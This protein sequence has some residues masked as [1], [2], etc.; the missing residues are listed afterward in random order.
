MLGGKEGTLGC[1]QDVGGDGE[2][3]RDLG[4]G[5]GTLGTLWFALKRD[6]EMEN[7]IAKPEGP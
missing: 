5:D 6:W 1:H 4:A 7:A 2:K 3:L